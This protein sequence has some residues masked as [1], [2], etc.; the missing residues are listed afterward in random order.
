MGTSLVDSHEWGDV[1]R[2]VERAGSESSGSRTAS[3][4]TEK[5]VLKRNKEA[6]RRDRWF[7][8]RRVLAFILAVLA[9]TGIAVGVGYGLRGGRGPST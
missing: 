7:S 5:A 4:M 9:L 6:E 2:D 3:E 1:G 8:W